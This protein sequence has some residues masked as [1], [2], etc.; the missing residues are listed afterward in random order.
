M[1]QYLQG[2]WFLKIIFYERNKN[3]GTALAIATL[4][5]A[6][7]GSGYSVH[8]NKQAV[9]HAKNETA[10]QLLKT[11][12]KINEV[13]S[14]ESKTG[15][16]SVRKNVLLSQSKT[17]YTTPLGAKDSGTTIKKTILGG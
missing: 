10:K 9:D 7:V 12:N 14:D 13:G 3:M 15:S 16:K 17:N 2:K 4:T 6:A 11:M 1:G 5:A 8:K